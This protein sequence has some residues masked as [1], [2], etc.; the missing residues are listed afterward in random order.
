V[1]GG[2][3][4]LRLDEHELTLLRRAVR[5]ADLC[6]AT[7]ARVDDDGA[8]G[9]YKPHPALVE[10]RQQ[11]ITLARLIVVCPHPWWRDGSR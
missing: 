2:A 7:Q 11:R 1:A 4:R 5:T 6:E 10:L 8:L 3:G 9:A